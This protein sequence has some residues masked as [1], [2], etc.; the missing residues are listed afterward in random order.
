VKGRLRA[1][2]TQHL[3]A[4]GPAH[5]HTERS[6]ELVS[7][8][9]EG[10]E[11]LD[12]YL[13]QYQ[14][15]R[16]LAGLVPSLVVLAVLLLDPWTVLVLLFAGPMLVL[17]LALIGGR[18]RELNERRFRELSWMSAHFLDMLQGLP[19]LKMF[20][21]SKEQ[22]ETIDE[23]SRQFG[24]TTM[25][26]LRTAFQTSLVLEWAAV[27]GTA[28]VAV[29]VSLRLM[30]GMLPFDRALTVLLLAPEF[31]L[32]LRQLGLKYHAGTA[33]KAAAQR[34]FAILDTPASAQASSPPPTGGAMGMLPRRFD[35]QCAGVQYAYQGGQ[36]P[37]LQ[38]L[39]LTVPHGQTVA[40]VGPSGAG[41]TTVANLLLRFVEPD[42]GAIFVGG[43]P[44]RDLDRAAWR[45]L[46]GWVPQ[47][48]YLFHGTIAD[49]IRLA[50]P[51]AGAAE[52]E[53]AARAAHAH[54][55][56]QAL[57]HGYDTPINER[58]T[59]LSGGQRQ[60]LAIARALLK[61]APVLILDE[62]TSHLDAESEALIHD[63][64]LRLMRG[65]TV[66]IIAHR[67]TMV[68]RA[69]QIVVLDQGRVVESGSHRALLAA[70]GL[71]R[72]LVA[73]YEGEDLKNF[74]PGLTINGHGRVTAP[75]GADGQAQTAYEG[76]PGWR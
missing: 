21:R 48:P 36:R 7:T 23:I 56:I 20:G 25:G 51:D 43:M 24:D 70:G 66:L 1:R 71:Y 15:A 44:L 16:L 55:F 17:M 64:L 32:P 31:F 47:H 63:A 45:T 42:A 13:T 6:G 26:V 22:V 40:L 58:G 38:G 61:D 62:A 18:T 8:L 57:P 2:L 37:A 33:G 73:T 59:R 75:E 69:D 65:R 53:A 10:V 19:T 11:A 12:E 52:I 67:L 28:F 72:T 54:E 68:Y 3:F 60:R 34:I 74:A 30:H 9:V 35:I 5:I 27:A 14:P 49:N 29:E 50:R 41:K 39:T 76:V 4:L 46:V